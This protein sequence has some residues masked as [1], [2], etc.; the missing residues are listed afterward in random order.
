MKIT[1][2]SYRSLPEALWRRLRELLPKPQPHP[3]GGRPLLDP[4]RVANGI[5]YVMRTGCPWKAA[6]AEF[7]SGSSLHRYFQA[8]CKRGVF[9]KLWKQGLVEY[10]RRKGIGWRWQTLDAAMTKAPLG[11][12]KNRAQSDR[13]RQVGRETVGAHRCTRRR[14]GLGDRSGE[15]ARPQAGRADTRQHADSSPAASAAAS[16]ASVRRQ[17]VRCERLS[18][19][20]GASPLQAAHQIARRRGAGKT[21]ASPRQGSPLGE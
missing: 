11:G 15:P 18:T 21:S 7:G 20:V 14:L 10:D 2:S 13:P 16:A 8:W 4:R 9:R 6:P 12:E 1:A 3:K 19:P 5:Y 17:S